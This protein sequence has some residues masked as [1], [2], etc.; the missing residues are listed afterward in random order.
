MIAILPN[1]ITIFRICGSIALMFIDPIKMYVA[2]LVLYTLAGISDAVDGWIAR[3][4]HVTSELGTKLDTIADFLF[5]AVMFVK[6]LPPLIEQLP[7]WVWIIGFTI[8]F[9][10]ICSYVIAAIKYHRFAT[11]H[12][13]LNKLTGINIFIMPYFRD[14]LLPV[15]IVLCFVAGTA[16]LEELI[17]HIRSKTYDSS[18][19]TLLFTKPKK[20]NG[21]V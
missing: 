15:S 16:T 18:R 14:Y 19:K 11:L 4:F 3:H 5:Y 20:T 21:A 13:Y 10:R 7:L 9:L 8:I 17:I 1:I 6:F 12:T 2:F